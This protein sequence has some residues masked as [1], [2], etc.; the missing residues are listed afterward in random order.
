MKR[1]LGIVLTILVVTTGLAFAG[2]DGEAGSTQDPLEIRWFGTR[3]YPGEGTAIPGMIEELV[4]EKVG[5]P[6][7]FELMGGVG[8]AEMEATQEM[9][10]AAN[11]LPDV[12]QRFGG[13]NYEFN[14]QAGTQFSLDEYKA[15][16]PMQYKWLTE[17]MAQ[18][19]AD[20]AST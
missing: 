3:S 20:E 5:Y 14:R 4:S 13:T 9:L 16:M 7:T 11:D 2:G 1:V 6:V 8:D 19:G 15:N 18:L 17:L 10:L 12:F